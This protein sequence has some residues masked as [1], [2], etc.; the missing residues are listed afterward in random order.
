[1]GSQLD[2]VCLEWRQVTYVEAHLNDPQVWHGLQ[3]SDSW[4]SGYLTGE[5]LAELRFWMGR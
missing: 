2:E 3:D 5:G 4:P 1:V